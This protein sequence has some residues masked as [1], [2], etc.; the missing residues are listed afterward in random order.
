MNPPDGFPRIVP[1]LIYD[2]VGAAV[3]WL[4]R[5]FGFSERT[6]ARHLH[7]DGTV[8]RTQLQVYDSVMTVGP[9]S[10][11]GQSPSGGVSS[12]LLVYI[13]DVDAHYERARA[14][15]ASI[16]TPLEELPWGDRR[17]QASDPEGHQWTFA[18]HVR[19]VDLSA[20]PH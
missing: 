1:H 5:V 20:V 11:H 6:W 2:D 4:C 13:D 14:E 15:G 16:V 17:Y 3:T 9:P 7:A 18:Q 19:D 10:V 12:M 8:G